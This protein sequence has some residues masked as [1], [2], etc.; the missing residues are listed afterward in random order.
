M[1]LRFNSV[2]KMLAIAAAMAVA[3]S[4]SAQ[5][6]G[7]WT[8]KL[9]ANKITP[10]VESGDVSAPALPGTKG[11]AGSNTQPVLVFAYGLSD[12]I[13]TEFALG[14]PYKTPLYGAG[15][16]QGVGK[17][18]SVEVLPPTLFIQYR[19]FEPT[20]MFR[21]YVGVGVTYAYFMKAKGSGQLTAITNTG[22]STPT[23]F[24]IDNKVAGTLQ[25]GLVFNISER[26]FADAAYTKTYLKT[27]VNY[28]TGQTQDMTLDPQGVSVGIGY[29]F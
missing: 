25:A 27:K 17:I 29:K 7:Q 22:G 12:N 1:K 18:A 11:D 21:P 24:K 10:K 28:S 4:A 16:I 14:T 20:S 6:A 26:W 3:S 15:S 8:A 13:S 9:G 23:T 5:S 2:V 19:F